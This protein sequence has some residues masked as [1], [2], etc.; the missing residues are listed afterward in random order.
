MSVICSEVGENCYDDGLSALCAR[1]CYFI[2]PV[3]ET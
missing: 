1:N 3:D 2:Y